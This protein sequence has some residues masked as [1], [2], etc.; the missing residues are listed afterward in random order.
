MAYLTA[1]EPL[2]PY[3]YQGLIVTNHEYPNTGNVHGSFECWDGQWV[4]QYHRSVPGL[5]LT[6]VACLDPLEFNEDGTIREVKMSSSGIRG[7]FRPGDKIQASAAVEYSLGRAGAEMVELKRKEYPV[8]FFK[9]DGQWVGYRYV[10]FSWAPS[11]ITVSVKSGQPGGKLEVRS[12]APDGPV[13]ATMEVPDTGWKWKEQTV[14]VQVDASGKEAVYLVAKV[15]PFR[16]KYF[17][18]E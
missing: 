2:G 4:V 11:T 5:A 8:I 13:M 15:A 7:A 10:D 6:R 14:P 1:K 9:A 17:R 3:T 18:F 12:G 16:V